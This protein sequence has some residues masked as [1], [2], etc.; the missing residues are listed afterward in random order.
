[1][2]ICRLLYNGQLSTLSPPKS[3]HI[4]QPLQADTQTKATKRVCI[5]NARPKRTKKQANEKEHRSDNIEGLNRSEAQRS[6][7]SALV[8]C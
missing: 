2:T 5:A 7:G 1:M 8:C 3:I 4:L 6:E